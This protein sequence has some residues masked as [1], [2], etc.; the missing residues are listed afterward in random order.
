MTSGCYR[1]LHSWIETFVES[2]CRNTYQQSI[3]NARA[4]KHV[5]K[6]RTE[7]NWVK[8]RLPSYNYWIRYKTKRS[9]QLNDWS[10]SIITYSM[11]TETKGMEKRNRSERDDW[12]N[13]T[14]FTIFLCIFSMRFFAN[15]FF[16]F[17][18]REKTTKY[19]NFLTSANQD[20]GH[21]TVHSAHEQKKINRILCRDTTTIIM[22]TCLFALLNLV[23]DVFVLSLHSH[24]QDT[25]A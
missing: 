5:F 11:E 24:H 22:C 12:K 13:K 21:G 16:L 9:Q 1:R 19:V 10:A 17:V 3:T 6:T 20:A 25:F 18:C 2:R 4:L 23:L 7:I 14:N 15:S 8:C